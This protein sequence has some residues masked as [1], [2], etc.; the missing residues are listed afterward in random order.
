MRIALAVVASM[1]LSTSASAYQHFVEYRIGG[2][3]IERVTAAPPTETEAPSTLTIKVK[4]VFETIDIQTDSD[5]DECAKRLQTVL[6]NADF[7]VVITVDENAETLNG[8]VIRQC[9]VFPALNP[10]N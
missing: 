9:T 7:Y 3:Q 8:I 2:S 1:V 5:A 4:D 6:G 10:A